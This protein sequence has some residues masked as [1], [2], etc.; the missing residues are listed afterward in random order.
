[1]RDN[2]RFL[3]QG[4]EVM[5]QTMQHTGNLITGYHNGKSHW[6]GLIRQLNGE[7]ACVDPDTVEFVAVKPCRVSSFKATTTETP[8]DYFECPTCKGSV[9][10]CKVNELAPDHGKRGSRIVKPSFC[11]NCGQRLDWTVSE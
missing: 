5:P 8:Y 4:Q 1:V 7:T 3:V 11:F 2:K 10:N 9:N 6:C